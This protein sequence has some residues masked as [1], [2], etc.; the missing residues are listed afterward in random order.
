MQD[1]HEALQ[2]MIGLTEELHGQAAFSG[3]V[4]DKL[5]T[6]HRITTYLTYII[7]VQAVVL[8]L[9]LEA[10]PQAGVDVEKL[11]ELVDAMEAQRGITRLDKDGYT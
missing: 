6:V 8:D 10:V 1:I 11:T 9:L 5:E 2:E 4:I 3:S 7:G